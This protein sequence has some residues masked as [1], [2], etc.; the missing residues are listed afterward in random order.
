MSGR[1]LE[2][3][4]RRCYLHRWPSQRSRKRIRG[5][6]KALI[7]RNRCHIDIRQVNADLNP[8]LRGWGATSAPA[9]P[10]PSSTRTSSGG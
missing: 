1:L 3:S 6:V 7:G 9:T 8:I 10:P 5:R 2:R 4:I